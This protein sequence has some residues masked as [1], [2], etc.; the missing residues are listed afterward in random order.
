M[1]VYYISQLLYIYSAFMIIFFSC[2]FTLTFNESN[3]GSPVN[4]IVERGFTER[5]ALKKMSPSVDDHLLYTNYEY[6]DM[7]L[8][9]ISPG[10]KARPGRDADHSPPSS[11]EVV[12]E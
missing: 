1:I 11:A 10:V 12:N 9:L 4:P 3:L 5:A 2:S 6:V 8:I 7:H